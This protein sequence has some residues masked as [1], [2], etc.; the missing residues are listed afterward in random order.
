MSGLWTLPNLLGLFRLV[1]TPVLAILILW[2]FPGSGLVAFIL[3]VPAALSDLLDG[4]LA[5]SRGQVTT[6]GA[7]LDL[8][9]DKV[10]VAALL[11]ALVQAGLAP[12]WLVIVILVREFLVGG[13]RQVA[14]TEQLLLGSQIV[15]KAK[16]VVI[17][18]AIGFLLVAFDA[19]T[20]GPTATLGIGV[21]AEIVGTWLLLAGMALAIVS[22][23]DYLSRAWP[24]LAGRAEVDGGPPPT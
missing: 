9:A 23:V 20:G 12:A 3:F 8:T 19:Q 6:L 7:F 17:L 14:A 11:I 18:V 2:P 22:G 13:V 5:R 16:T 4:W 1:A 10:L 24:L 21:L 15:G